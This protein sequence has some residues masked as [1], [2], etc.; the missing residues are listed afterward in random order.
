[1]SR[2]RTPT[3]IAG[4]DEYLRFKDISLRQAELFLAVEKITTYRWLEYAY[5]W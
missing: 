5:P 1:M 4:R 3:V 2:A